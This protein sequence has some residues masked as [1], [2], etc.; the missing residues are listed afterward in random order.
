MTST[1]THVT[2]VAAGFALFVALCNGF[3]TQGRGFKSG[4]VALAA[5]ISAA[6][7]IAAIRSFG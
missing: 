5:G 4:F 1:F 7:I 3:P 2:A 6:V